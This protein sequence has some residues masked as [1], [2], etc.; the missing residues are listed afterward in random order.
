MSVAGGF[1]PVVAPASVY[2]LDN[3]YY[4][5]DEEFVFAVADALRV[6]YRAIVDSGFF[7]QLDDAVL[8]HEYDSI[9]SL[10]G[11]VEDYRRW[12]Q[13]RIDALKHTP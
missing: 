4:K 1:L 6:E 8:V 11:S 2:W 5:S 3:K 13:V 7:L 9:L 10:G 12:A